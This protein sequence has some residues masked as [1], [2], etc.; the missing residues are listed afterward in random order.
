MKKRLLFLPIM[1]G[2][3]LSGCDFDLGPFHIHD[4]QQNQQNQNNNQGQGDDHNNEQEQQQA[5]VVSVTVSGAPASITDE[6]APFQL[7]ADVVV[8]NNASKE[9][10]WSS[11]NNSVATV[12]ATGLIT[13][14]TGGSVTITATSKV[15][16]SKKGSVTLNISVVPGVV[17]VEIQ[18]APGKID[19]TNSNVSLR[20]EVVA[21]GNAGTDVKW[22]SSNENVATIGASS[23]LVTPLSEGT[24]TFTATA[25][26]D[27]SKKDSVTI[28]IVNMTPFEIELENCNSWLASSGV[29]NPL[30]IPEP[31]NTGVDGEYDEE[32]YYYSFFLTSE[33]TA[34]AYYAQLEEAGFVIEGEDSEKVAYNDDVCISVWNPIE[35]QLEIDVY[36]LSSAESGQV[37]DVDDLYD[38]AEVYIVCLDK[39]FGAGAYNGTKKFIGVEIN[40]SLEGL[41]IFVLTDNGD[42]TWGLEDENGTAY[43]ADSDKNIKTSGSGVDFDW[44]IEIDEFGDATLV[45]H[46]YIL[47]FNTDGNS[48]KTY[49]DGMATGVAV[50][51]FFADGEISGGGGGGGSSTEEFSEFPMQQVITCLDGTTDETFPVPT[52][53]SFTFEES[54]EFYYDCFVAVEGGD[55][56]TYLGSLETAKFDI[57]DEYAEEGYYYCMSNGKTL[58]IDIIA[59]SNSSFEMEI[60]SCIAP[61]EFSEF[62]LARVEEVLGGSVSMPIPTGT[63]FV[64]YDSEYYCSVVV[65]GGDMNAYLAALETAG[66]EVID[67]SE[68]GFGI[69]AYKGELTLDFEEY[70]DGSYEIMI[71]IFEE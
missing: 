24:V 62:P 13:P 27:E 5:K 45:C 26:A 47:M 46:D 58:E 28:K 56:T 70:E 18:N 38:G 16:S 32:Y 30:H 22:T 61:E 66:F 69:E 57:D 48:F 2:L 17:S 29:E 39:G 67:Y 55:L 4:T 71:F 33:V 52:G 19:L 11:S 41:T 6:S 54:E 68:F 36:L 43:G 51:I 8:E 34:E 59:E 53:T 20:A 15:D 63:S 31:V 25:L 21:K 35:G 64:F 60:Y 3:V 44:T 50:Q 49:A 23:G 12:S 65:N 1:A 37:F 14:K 7:T 9:V 10:T 40:E 42:G